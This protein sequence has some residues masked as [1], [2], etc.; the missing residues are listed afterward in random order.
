M[1]LIIKLYH[2]LLLTFIIP[3]GIYAQTL[4]NPEVTYTQSELLH[5][6]QRLPVFGRVLYIAAHPDD[7]NTRLISWLVK[8]KKLEAAYL[9]LTRG[10]GGQ[11]LIGEEQ[12]IELG[13]IR[14]QELLAARKKDGGKQFFTRAYDFG[15]SKSAN[16]TLKKWDKEKILSDIV[17][18]IRYFRPDIIICRFPVTGEGGHGHHTAS[19]ILAREAFIAAADKNKFSE[20]L[21]ELEIWQA[22]RLL[23]NTFNFGS[24]NTIAEDQ[25]K[26]DVGGYNMLLGKS[27]GE[28]AAESRSQH[29]SQGFGTEKRRGSQ[30]EYFKTI[31]G[32]SPLYD[33]MDGVDLSIQ[34]I[35]PVTQEGKNVYIYFNE[36]YQKLTQTSSPND[37]T[38]LL[39]KIR[40][41]LLLIKPDIDKKYYPY[42]DEK[43]KLCELLIAYVN[44]L[45][46]DCNS[47]EQIYA[48]GDVI[49]IN[50]KIIYRNNETSMKLNA[51]KIISGEQIMFDSIINK[52]LEKNTL[53]QFSSI[54][55]LKN[56][57][58]TQ[59]YWLQEVMNENLYTY[60][61]P[62][63]KIPWNDNP[64]YA[65]YD[66]EINR[67]K[68][69]YKVP[70]QYKYINPGIGE[71][72]QPIEISPEI[73][74]NSAE[75]LVIFNGIKDKKIKVT[76]K[77]F[78][79]S[80]EKNIQI[81]LPKGWTCKPAQLKVQLA[82]K[83][84]EKTYELL[85][86][87][88]AHPT[89]VQDE[90]ISFLADKKPVSGYKKI[91]YEHLPLI[92]YFPQ[93]KIKLINAN[94]NN[95]N[96]RI[97]YI[98]GAGDKIPNILKQIGY[99]VEILN[100]ENFY[101]S[102][103]K[104]Y[105][106]IIT[107]VRAYNTE[108]WLANAQSRLLEYVYNGGTLL[109][110]YNTSM[111]LISDRLG[112]YPFKLSR[113]RVCEE[114][115]KVDFINDKHI[116]LQS[117]NNITEEDFK[118]WIQERGLY[119]TADADKNYEKIFAMND[120]GENKND[121]SVLY[122]KYGKGKYIYTSLSFFRQ[123]PAGN[124]GAIKLFVN[125]IEN[126]HAT[127]Q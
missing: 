88:P 45:W 78:T 65:V 85:L 95:S 3:A 112:P 109:Q 105:A 21:K 13:L 37:F 44:G 86:T 38:E 115:A 46:M 7:E 118:G 27:Y 19:A 76:V 71:I 17:Y 102:D 101:T 123:L 124:I 11:N 100:E 20:Q 54:F 41:K 119:F 80:V 22:K 55:P 56:T 66:L 89:I 42:T 36:L 1:Q 28:I 4:F 32:E 35:L 49:Q 96:S 122:A 83:G 58:I 91:V 108:K 40:N 99:T 34:K 6:M 39:F 111:N 16:E 79:D 117:P 33:I 5:Q 84:E 75:E 31:I 93:T 47:S 25:F 103:L 106:C 82:K 14:T 73:T 63:L 10:D 97:G 52:P 26:V 62:L 77:T 60:N 94:F 120:E 9:S 127:K 126:N 74:L 2:F 15:Y 64:L 90:Y 72:Y 98:S 43:I 68:V 67:Q 53:L 48:T 30:P 51:V 50:T 24:R 61:T 104:D 113:E 81:Q 110:Q 107:G 18:I 92:T 23:W 69:Q 12:G 8:E 29:R 114:D 87:A 116:L 125:F 59:P 121:G 57:G 70:V